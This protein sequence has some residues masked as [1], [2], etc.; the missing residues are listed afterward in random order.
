MVAI[1]NCKKSLSPSEKRKKVEKRTDIN[2][3]SITI[4]KNCR[5]YF[6]CECSTKP[7]HTNA[8]EQK[9]KII[10]E[11]ITTLEIYYII[12]ILKLELNQEKKRIYFLENVDKLK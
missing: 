4:V 9:Y 11:M 1:T 5:I 7:T 10:P 8:D 2:H 3:E 12:H 6:K